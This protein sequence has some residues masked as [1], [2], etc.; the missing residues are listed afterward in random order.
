MKNGLLVWNVLLTLIAGYLLVMHFS[1]NKTATINKVNTTD[2]SGN[3]TNFRIAYFEMDS[4]ATNF[5]KVKELKEEMLKKEN[6][7]NN[8]L[9][10]MERDYNN[11]LNNYQM[12]AQAQELTQVESERATQD[13]MKT[14]EDIKKRKM[15]MDQDYNDFVI[16]EQDKIKSMIQEFLKDYNKTK[17]YSYIVSYEQGLF[18]Y[19][20]TIYNI[21][22]D[23]VKGLNSKYGGKK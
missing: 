4:I 10:R 7:I 22:E 6:D 15:T 5:G 14:Q 9:D 8:E 3:S 11:K 18:Y 2:S 13:L 19:K 16:R 1:G 12:K 23:V 17:G 21:T 20:D